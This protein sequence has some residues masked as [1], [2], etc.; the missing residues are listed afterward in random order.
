[1]LAHWVIVFFGQ[2]LKMTKVGHILRLTFS[3]GRGYVLMMTQNGSGYILGH[4]FTN[5]SGRPEGKRKKGVHLLQ[6]SFPKT[7]PA[8]QGEQIGRIFAL[9]VIFKFGQFLKNVKEILFLDGYF[10]PR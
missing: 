5:S 10:F 4:F 6:R 7:G 9:W 3:Q 2:F 8:N 1:M